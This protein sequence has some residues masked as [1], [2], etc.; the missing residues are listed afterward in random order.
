MDLDFKVQGPHPWTRVDIKQPIGSKSL[1]K[2]GQTISLEDMAYKLGQKIVAQKHRF[3]G[4]S[5]VISRSLVSKLN[6]L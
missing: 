5:N 2:Q 1:I 6:I 3:V 4:L